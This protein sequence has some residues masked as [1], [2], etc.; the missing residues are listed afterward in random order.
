MV[1]IATR[2]N[3]WTNLQEALTIKNKETAYEQGSSDLDH[4]CLIRKGKIYGIG[5]AS[6]TLNSSIFLMGWQKK[7]LLQLWKL[8]SGLSC[9]FSTSILTFKIRCFLCLRQACISIYKSS[10]ASYAHR[11]MW[12]LH[13]AEK[14][15]FQKQKWKA[16]FI[17]LQAENKDSKLKGT[18]IILFPSKETLKGCFFCFVLLTLWT[19][20][21]FR[22]EEGCMY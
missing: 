9:W 5:H 8:S 18:I 4:G 22:Q 17:Q 7:G 14:Q 11:D 6:F 12:S 21:L 3:K 16:K 10:P 20:W 2:K 19:L 1:F 13:P 15:C